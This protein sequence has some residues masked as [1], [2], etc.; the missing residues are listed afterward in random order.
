M[1]SP[2]AA[3]LLQKLANDSGFDVDAGTLGPWVC[4]KSSQAPLTVW[5][6]EQDKKVWIA[7]FSSPAV[8]EAL[9]VEPMK[10]GFVAHHPRPDGAAGSVV[11]TDAA[12]LYPWLRRAFQLAQALPDAPLQELLAIASSLPTPSTTEVM[13]EVKRRKGQE[14]FRKHL[15]EDWQSRCAVT[16]L[17]VEALLVASHIKPWKEATD[18]ER[19]DVNNGLILAAHVDRAFDKGFLTFDDDGAPVVAAALDVAA[20]AAAGLAGL[21]PITRP[22]RPQHKHYLAWHRLNVFQKPTVA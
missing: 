22:L 14:I 10:K 19:L 6:Q 7:A 3:D 2:L 20:R 18:A 16:G 12:G 4:R 1:T 8:I 11:V 21:P 9:K 5:L 15:L 13:A 17:A